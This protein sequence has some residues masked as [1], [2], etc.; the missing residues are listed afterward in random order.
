MAL[1]IA[2]G[3]APANAQ[4]QW[5]GTTST[6]WFTPGNWNPTAVP[7]TGTSVQIN[8]IL[9]NATVIGTAG[10]QANQLTL[11]NNPGQLG[12]LTVDGPGTLALTNASGFFL[13]GN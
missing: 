4:T 7:G 5:T 13:V 3:I 11:G 10:A 1:L 6:D 2:A 9:P 12:N 8:T